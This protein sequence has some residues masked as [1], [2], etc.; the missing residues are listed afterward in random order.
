MYLPLQS[1]VEEM[2][3]ADLQNVRRPMGIQTSATPRPCKPSMRE[4]LGETTGQIAA[5][6]KVVL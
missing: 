4:D 2:V 1:L 5:Y 3:E 6:R